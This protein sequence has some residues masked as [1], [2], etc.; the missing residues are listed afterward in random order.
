MFALLILCAGFVGITTVHLT[1]GTKVTIISSIFLS[2]GA[3]WTYSEFYEES[4]GSV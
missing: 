2:N 4:E 1:L 3:F